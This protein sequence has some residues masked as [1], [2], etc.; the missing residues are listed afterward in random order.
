[1]RGV[2]DLLGDVGQSVSTVLVRVLH[3][4]CLTGLSSGVYTLHS[5]S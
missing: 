3:L 4:A 2:G 1:M 5:T